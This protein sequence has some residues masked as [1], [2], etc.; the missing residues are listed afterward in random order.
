MANSYKSEDQH[1]YNVGAV[2]S[3]M[4]P[5]TNII[6]LK[7]PALGGIPETHPAALAKIFSQT[8]ANENLSAPGIVG[9]ALSKS[10]H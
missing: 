8:N 7:P 2:G 6:H 3:C 4:S 9:V 5:V 1:A 10:T